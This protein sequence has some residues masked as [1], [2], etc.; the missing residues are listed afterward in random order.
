M[1]Y[2]QQKV[3][4]N[5]DLPESSIRTGRFTWFNIAL[6]KSNS[7]LK[8]F[9]TSSCLNKAIIKCIYK[10]FSLKIRFTLPY[11]SNFN[12]KT[13]LQTIVFERKHIFSDYLLSFVNGYHQC[14]LLGI[15]SQNIKLMLHFV[16]L[17]HCL[18]FY[19]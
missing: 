11:G 10:Q 17:S 12:F 8:S 19:L 18:L 4:V 15:L 3:H 13:R 14:F 16:W 7:L 6:T 9:L 5:N 2:I 1:Y